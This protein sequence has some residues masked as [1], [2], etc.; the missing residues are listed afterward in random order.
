[1]YFF[2]KGTSNFMLTSLNPF[3]TPSK[4]KNST[5]EIESCN[6]NKEDLKLLDNTKIPHHVAIIPDGN[7]RWAKTNNLDISQGHRKGANNLIT[8]VKAAKE[9][10]IKCITFFLFSTENWKREQTEIKALMWLLEFFL[11]KQRQ[12]MIDN[13]I[14]FH[15]IGDHSKF[16]NRIINEL[17]KSKKATEHCKTIDMVAA[18][19]Y[20]ARNEMTRAIHRILEDCDKH[21][22]KNNAIDECMISKYLDTH[23]WPDPELL[24]RTSGEK[25][26]SNFLLWQLSYSEIYFTD[27][28]WPE[29]TANHLLEALLYFQS[30]ERRLG[31]G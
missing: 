28:L 10:G 25:R 8:L 9:L 27:V 15:T 19:N 21:H 6:F 11:R 13:D 12:S 20:G 7:R 26:I 22:I 3:T 23:V 18:L 4:N 1:M 30:R 5:L 14:R 31:G 29:F 2:Q 17:E 16:S 24:I